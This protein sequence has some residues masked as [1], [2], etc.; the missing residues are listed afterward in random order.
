MPFYRRHL[1]HCLRSTVCEANISAKS[2]PAVLFFLPRYFAFSSLEEAAAERRRRKRQLRIEPPIHRDSGASRSTRN[3]NTLRLPDATAALVGPRLSL[4]NRIQTLIRAGDLDAASVQ[5]RHA[6]FSPIKPTV[7]T[8]NAVMSSMLR[9]S[10]FGDVFALFHFFFT[11]QNIIPNIVSYNILI[12]AHCDA[13]QVNTALDVYRQILHNAPFT[14]STY[15]Y[16]YLIK[17]LVDSSRIADAVSLLREMLNRGH[18][19]DTL[20][21]DIVIA[22]FIALNDMEKAIEL[23]DELRERCQ[24]YDGVVHATLMKG[25]WK[26]GMDKEAM[27]CYQS[28][29]DR[30]FRMHPATCNVLLETLLMHDKVTEA[31]QLFDQMLD[32]HKPPVFMG[33]NA[34]SYSIMINHCFNKGKFAEAIETFNTTGL[35]PLPKDLG[36]YNHIIGKLCENGMVQDAVKLFEEMLSQ[37]VEPDAATYGFII[38]AYFRDCRFEDAMVF[39][40][41]LVNGG[42]GSL[43]AALEIC[44]KMVNELVKAGCLV[45]ALEV[46]RKMGVSGTRPSMA[47]Y[48]V[49][50]T[51]LCKEGDFDSVLAL[52]EEM[53]K[54]GI[55]VSIELQSFVSESFE[56]AG[57]SLDIELLLASCAAAAPRA[58]SAQCVEGKVVPRPTSSQQVVGGIFAPSVNLQAAA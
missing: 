26:L 30:Q 28:L 16:R 9:A 55:L 22:G 49:L 17:G 47:T 2:R 40:D 43:K 15:T 38:D 27:E 29:L 53:V 21:Y 25:Y 36:R 3:S 5:A 34:E 31:E 32:E 23:F 37:S 41:K 6:I 13:G 10:R 35:K 48:E 1:I 58:I 56:K 45:Q 42:D 12:N 33:I 14:P 24:V 8:C 51:G 20:V 54:C 50:I 7:F 39:F 52:F 46:V 57:R 19:A 18:S 4:H 44:N 11:Q